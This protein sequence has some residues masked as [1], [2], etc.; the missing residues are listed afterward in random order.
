MGKGWNIMSSY[1]SVH[2]NLNNGKGNLVLVSVKGTNIDAVRL[3]YIVGL[4]IHYCK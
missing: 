2:F 1:M 3:L 4:S